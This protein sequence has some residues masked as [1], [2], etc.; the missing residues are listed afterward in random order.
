MIAMRLT[1]S[2]LFKEL[3]QLVYPA[4]CCHCGE[5][6]VGDEDSLCTHCMC[7][8]TWARHA[9]MPNNDVELRLAGRVP[10]QA[11]AALFLFRQGSV[12]QDVVHQIKYH[13]NLHLAHRFG[14]L[15]GN[16]L[17]SSKRFDDI[18]C[19]VP[20]PLHPWRKWQRGYNQSELLCRAMAEVM[21]KPVITNNLIRRRYTSSQT[22]KSRQDRMDN[23]KAVFAVRRPKEF[24]NK[25]ILLV[26]DIITTG[27]T[28]ENCYHALRS[29][30]NLK[31]SVAA[32]AVTSH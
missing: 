31:I 12:V 27:A 28:T 6:L 14:C 32:L 7:H 5:P 19:L 26:D 8:L 24:E 15:L 23:M 3:L 22:H 11:A 20:V 29:V 21:G 25:H 30:D 4:L 18:D 17:V 13:G 2:Q 10:Y 9:A 1:P 16:E